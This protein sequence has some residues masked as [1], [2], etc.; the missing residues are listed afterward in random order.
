MKKSKVFIN[1]LIVLLISIFLIYYILKDNFT[2]SIKVLSSVNIFWLILT[3]I[4]YIIYFLMETI[5]FKQ[6]INEHKKG[7]S[8]KSSIKLHLMSKFFNGITPFSSGGQPFQLIE[9]K[10][11]GI[12][13]ANGTTV[14]IK[15]FLILQ[16]SIFILSIIGII[17]NL[18]FNFFTPIGILKILIILGI[19]INFL[20]IGIIILLSTKID[21]FQKLIYFFINILSKVKII[22]NKNET[23][24]KINKSSLDYQ[25][26]YQELMNNKKYFI[27]LVLIESLALLC[28]FSISFF[29]F[30]AVG[31]PYDFYIG[32]VTI[33]IFINL[34][35]SYI[36]I[37]GGTGGME[38]AFLNLFIFIIPKMYVGVS[39][40]LWR[41]I[42]YYL[43]MIIGGITF[44]YERTKRNLKTIK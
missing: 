4:I 23:I 14:L 26:S 33:S 38:Y 17:S 29:A 6:L 37:P 13:Y 18:I 42:D 3:I 11:E 9:L 31:S 40:I 20:L 24:E 27:K 15:H 8:Y 22:K 28:D 36:P 7:Y 44:N 19:I 34:I 41:I 25:K 32:Y 2:M 5:I 30:K 43:P 39:L 12:S 16:S 1:S 10:K 35:G 21:I